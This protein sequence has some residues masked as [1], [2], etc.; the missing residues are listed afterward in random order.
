MVEEA[1]PATRAGRADDAG[2]WSDEA[3]EEDRAGRRVV[4]RCPM[5]KVRLLAVAAV[6]VNLTVGTSA[7]DAQVPTVVHFAACNAE[8]RAAVKERT[9]APILKDHTRAETA[10]RAKAVSVQPPDSGR[11]I[12]TD[13][14]DPQLVGMAPEGTMDAAYHAGYRTCMRRS[15]F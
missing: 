12:I 15:G 4:R 10:R 11:M 6:V 2:G 1:R 7:L 5:T 14:S 3:T 8:A 9:A 13:S